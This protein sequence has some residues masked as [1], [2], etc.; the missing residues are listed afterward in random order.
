MQQ[1]SKMLNPTSQLSDD[2]RPFVIKQAERMNNELGH[3]NEKDGIDCSI[4][5][6]KGVIYIAT[7]DNPVMSQRQCKCIAQ[8]K[9]SKYAKK[10]G[11][12][13]LMK[14]TVSDFKAI[15]SWQIQ[16][17]NLAAEYVK[18]K[19]NDWFCLLGQSGSG[20]THI[21]SAVAK[22]F[23]NRGYETKYVVWNVFIREL[24]TD[25]LNEKTMMYKFMK[26]PV[27]YIDDLFKGKYTDTDV[28]LAFDLL[29]YR[30]NNKLT[31]IITSELSFDNLLEIDSAIAGRIRERCGKFL[32]GI[33]EDNNRNYRLK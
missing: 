31:T 19:H 29:N 18:E 14:Y 28:T 2:P 32:F 6:N 13:N 30:Y 22:T 11:M 3:L 24:K 20:K 15:E 7:E 1:I 4:C 23:I 8:R 5:K 21:C 25:N 26:V 12:G 16:I 9:S 27:L 10:S 17:K 33:G